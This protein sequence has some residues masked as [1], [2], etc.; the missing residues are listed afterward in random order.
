MFIAKKP[1]S[2][3]PNRNYLIGDTIPD[4]VVS[5][6]AVKRLT[7]MGIIVEV[8]VE[9]PRIVDLTVDGVTITL[10]EEALQELVNILSGN[11]EDATDRI[12]ELDNM[13]LL[14]LV[15]ATDSRKTV[16]TAAKARAQALNEAQEQAPDEAQ[17][18]EESEGDQ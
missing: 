16:Q 4:G 8:E 13:D 2:F 18:G 3:G 7:K 12:K 11:A 14:F 5:P 10:P 17:E 6:D 1:C 15:N 9:A